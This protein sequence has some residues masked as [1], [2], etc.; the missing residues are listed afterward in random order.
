MP[1]SSAQI[2]EF[3]AAVLA[4]PAHSIFG[5]S[6]VRWQPGEAVLSFT[7]DAPCLGPAGEVH[8]GVVSLPLEPAATFALLPTLPEDSY[9]VTADIHVQLLKAIKPGSHVELVGRVLRAGRQL[10]FCEASAV[11]AGEICV[12][13]HLTKAIVGRTA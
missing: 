1:R 5:L 10:A 11:A 7:P 12:V 9:P 2:E 4:V 6:L 3:F 8:G 13:A